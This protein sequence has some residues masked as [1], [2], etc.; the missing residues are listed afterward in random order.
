MRKKRLIRLLWRILLLVLIGLNLAL[1]FGFSGENAA[2][3][4]QTSGTVTEKVAEIVVPDF[5]KKPV[6]EQKKIVK[7]MEPPVRKLAHFS[8]YASLGGLV[9]LFL[10]T[11]DGVV[12]MQFSGSVGFAMVYAATDELHQKFSFGRAASVKDMLIYTS[13][14]LVACT[15]LLLIRFLVLWAQK[16][17]KKIK[18]TVYTIPSNKIEKHFRFAVVADTHG[19]FNPNLPL[20]LRG[21]SPDAILI[22]GDLTEYSAIKQNDETVFDF[23]K[24]C[25]SIAPT[26]YSLGNHECGTSRN[27]N[28]FAKPRKKELPAEFEQRV[29][30]TGAI[31]LR[32]DSVLR[33]GVLFCGLESGFDNGKNAP[34]ATALARF[35]DADG[36]RVLLCHH[37]EYFVPYVRPTNI[38]LTVCGHA[39]GG[40]WRF[41]GRGVYAPDQG[42]FPK[43]TTGVID[44]R[45]VISR[46]LDDHTVIPRFNNPRELVLL[47]V[48]PQT[49]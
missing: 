6:E 32:N 28:L 47:D 24:I 20:L 29:A 42:L 37:P 35:A 49:E 13:G 44:D 25:V 23:L 26:Y 40:H 2:K 22:P 30:E 14:A 3:S 9:F 8:E 19:R 17:P 18:T 34:D 12:V 21:S 48:V 4:S 7:K 15:V 11:W 1:I 36:F 41:F 5:D 33:D 31:L 43:Y 27:G 46:G 38:D 10:L 45:C 39:H 16:K